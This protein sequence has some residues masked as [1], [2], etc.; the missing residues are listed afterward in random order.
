MAK[1]GLAQAFA[2]EL[3]SL[4]DALGISQE[5]LADRAGL[6][7]NYVGMIERLERNPTLKAIEG[8]ARALG[9]RPS[10]L[11]DRAENRSGW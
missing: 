9:T 3:R 6:H 2:A 11:V 4:R 10:V 8:L 1:R 7:R 5:E